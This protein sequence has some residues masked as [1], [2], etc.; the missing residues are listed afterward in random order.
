[1]PKILGACK[2][3]HFVP[4]VTMGLW[5]PASSA[6]CSPPCSAS[7]ISRSDVQRPPAMP[8]GGRE[9]GFTLIEVIVTLAIFGFALALIVGYKPPWSGGLGLRATAA[10]LAAE[11]RL[12]RSE[13]VLRNRPIAFEIDLVAHQFR[14]GQRAARQLPPHIEITLLTIAGEQR[15]VSRADIRFNPDGTSTGGRITLGDGARKIVVGVDW[16]S[17]RVSVADAR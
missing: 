6:P 11:L 7:M 15:D 12:A 9:V 3:R 5:W 17:G 2:Q 16:L 13:A 4:S 8:S 10:E 14:V 1:V